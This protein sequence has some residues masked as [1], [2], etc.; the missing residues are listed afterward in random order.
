MRKTAA[1]LCVKCGMRKVCRLIALLQ[2]D[3]SLL[4]I[5]YQLNC[6]SQKLFY[7]IRNKK[8]KLNV[9]AVYGVAQMTEVTLHSTYPCQD[10]L[11]FELEH[12]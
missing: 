5:V 12:A 2:K 6:C 3:H 9:N 7:L 10:A 1:E 11:L 4:L 8:I